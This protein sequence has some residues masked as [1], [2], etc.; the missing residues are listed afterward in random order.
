MIN[1]SPPFKG[2]NTRIPSIM[3]KGVYSGFPTD[4]HTELGTLV[5]N[6]NLCCFS[7]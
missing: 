5:K 1:R 3:P 6:G 4:C 2:L 7:G